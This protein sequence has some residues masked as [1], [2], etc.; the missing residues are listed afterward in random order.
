MHG[1]ACRVCCKVSKGWG[2]SCLRG[3]WVR[4]GH[5]EQRNRS[6]RYEELERCVCCNSEV[7]L[8]GV[9]LHRPVVLL[10]QRLSLPEAANG[11]LF[12][13]SRREFERSVFLAGRFQPL[14]VAGADFSFCIET[15]RVLFRYARFPQR[16]L[17]QAAAYMI[18]PSVP[19]AIVVVVISA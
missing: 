15:H 12:V 8:Q 17:T 14:C 18:E 1:G 10:K 9:H 6:C 5:R 19:I 11:M 7:A 16:S 3:W 2:S 13:G 4:V